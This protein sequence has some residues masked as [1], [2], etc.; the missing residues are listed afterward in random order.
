MQNRIDPCTSLPKDIIQLILSYV[1]MTQLF[2]LKRLSKQ[3]NT[4]IH[5]VIQIILGRPENVIRTISELPARKAMQFI[6]YYRETDSYKALVAKHCADSS[7][8][9]PAQLICYAL[10]TNDLEPSHPRKKIES[11][12]L[13]NA[14]NLMS[15]Q[16]SKAMEE[17]L[18]IM[19]TALQYSEIEDKDIA[20]NFT[21]SRSVSRLMQAQLIKRQNKQFINF[22]SMDFH[23][24][25]FKNVNLQGA[26]LAYSNL[27][28]A[29]LSGANLNEAN[30][31]QAL[32][33]D[34]CAS[35]ISLNNAA[36]LPP[37]AFTSV[38]EFKQAL[39]QVIYREDQ[40]I[41]ALLNEA[42]TKNIIS[43]LSK[44]GT[45]ASSLF[46]DTAIELLPEQQGLIDF[47]QAMASSNYKAAL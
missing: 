17:N 37:A 34:A 2:T 44:M 32:L 29:Y 43:T 5:E 12:D 9:M 36:F 45:E 23:A 26:N 31:T 28:G 11:A 39:N 27:K 40:P 10:T 13:E 41:A 47:Q 7:K 15:K 4:L 24:L 25:Y 22:A 1:P 16:L 8:M 3:H 19:L 14:I 42:I 21:Q 35:T 30:L 18:R 6:E 38:A 33:V 46:I 20:E